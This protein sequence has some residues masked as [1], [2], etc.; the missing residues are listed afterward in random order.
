MKKMRVAIIGQGRSGRD[1]HGKYFL[2]EEN[3]NIEVKYVVDLIP[4]R[5]EIAEK[6]YKCQTM[7]DYRELFGK[8][9]VDLVVNASYSEQ[10]YAITKELLENGLNVLVEKPF[11]RTYYECYD[12][13]NTAKRNNAILAVFHQSLFAPSFLKVKEI[14]NSGKL[15]DVFQISLKYSGYARRWD[16]QTMQKHCGGS[17][18]NSGP[19]PIGQALDLLGWDKKVKIAFS[20]IK[21]LITSGDAEDYGKILLSCPNRPNVDIE[22]CSVDAFGND[23]VFKIFGTKGTL[24]ATNSHY[25]LKYVDLDNCEK[26]VLTEE[27]LHDENWSPLYCTEKLDFKEEEFDISGSSFDSAV[28]DYYDMVYGAVIKG[29]KLKITCEMAADVIRIIEAVHANN[30]MEIKY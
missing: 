16:W 11:S 19:H 27:P 10:H 21:P 26:R 12:L 6:T 14:I 2:S 13:I 8:K 22:I 7:S 30:P 1:I 17:V 3:D 15:G 4:E 9:D 5:R 28:K 29:E 20:D 18:Y 24:C 23:F 25:K